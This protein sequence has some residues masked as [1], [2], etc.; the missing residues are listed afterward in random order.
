M[1][2]NAVLTCNLTSIGSD[3]CWAMWWNNF[4]CLVFTGRKKSW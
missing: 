3:S 4:L 2:T 1:L